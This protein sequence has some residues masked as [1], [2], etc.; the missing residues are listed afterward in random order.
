MTQMQYIIE[1]PHLSKGV[2][3]AEAAQ[4]LREFELQFGRVEQPPIPLEQIAESHLKLDCYFDDLGREYGPDVL[5]ALA[6]EERTILI[7]TTLDPAAYPQLEGRYHFTLGHE[8]G[9]W[10]LHRDQYLSHMRLSDRASPDFLCSQSQRGRLERQADMFASYLLMPRPLIET[11]WS[12]CRKF[13]EDTIRR[14]AKRFRVSNTA[15]RIRLRE[16]RLI[17]PLGLVA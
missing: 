13:S 16:L 2:V 10:R 12:R 17:S 3:E 14:L 5:G 11:A 7:D 1:I 8:I 9:H 15:M 6:V 4:L